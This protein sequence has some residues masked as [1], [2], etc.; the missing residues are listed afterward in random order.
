MALSSDSNSEKWRMQGPA[1]CGGGCIKNQSFQDFRRQDR[2]KTR[3]KSRYSV[4]DL[5]FL[6]IFS[7]FLGQTAK[8]LKENAYSRLGQE[9]ARSAI[10]P[11]ES[12]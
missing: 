4:I 10:H 12:D 1:G 9:Y 8:I 5:S 7:G 2:K 6:A 11:M 3:K